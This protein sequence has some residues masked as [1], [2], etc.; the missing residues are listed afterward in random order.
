VQEKPQIPC[1]RRLGLRL[2]QLLLIIFALLLIK[3]C[4]VC[5]RHEKGPWIGRWPGTAIQELYLEKSLSGRLSPSLG[6]RSEKLTVRG[7]PSAKHILYIS[8]VGCICELS[9]SATW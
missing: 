8:S 9:T 1:H 4:R 2:L 6:P 5:Q 3:P 7:Q